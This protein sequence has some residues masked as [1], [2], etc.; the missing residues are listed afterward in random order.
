MAIRGCAGIAPVPLSLPPLPPGLH[1]R[2]PL[3]ACCQVSGLTP[4][5]FSLGF[6]TGVPVTPGTV[7]YVEGTNVSIHLGNVPPTC[8]HTD[9]AHTPCVADSPH[10][11]ALFFCHYVGRQGGNTLTMGPYKA[12]AELV[13]LPG[14][15]HLSRLH[16]T[17]PS[18]TTTTTHART[19]VHTP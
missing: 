2:H 13:Q 4:V 17:R 12:H 6:E 19:H 14:T 10:R 18:L 7:P 3:L 11:P 16:L 9:D 8:A 5:K 15:R 1:T